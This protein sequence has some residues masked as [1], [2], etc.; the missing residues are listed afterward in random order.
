VTTAKQALQ[1]SEPRF[2]SFHFMK[3]LPRKNP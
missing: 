2:S 3:S 1:K